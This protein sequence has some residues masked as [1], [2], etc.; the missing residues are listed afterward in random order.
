MRLNN[1]KLIKLRRLNYTLTTKI[2]SFYEA[3]RLEKGYAPKWLQNIHKQFT[4]GAFFH[5][6]RLTRVGNLLLGASYFIILI[7]ALYIIIRPT[8]MIN[9]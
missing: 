7:W 3:G 9:K 4:L 2:S 5:N 6:G 1:V 8:Q